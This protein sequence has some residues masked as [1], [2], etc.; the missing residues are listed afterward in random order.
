LCAAAAVVSAATLLATAGTA[1]T[2][3][4]G[5]TVFGPTSL[6]TGGQ[7]FVGAR[8]TPDS[9]SG[10]ATH[11][12]VT[13]TL[14]VAAVPTAPAADPGSS[15]DCGTATSDGTT[16][17]VQCT[18][19][20][21]NPGQTVKRFITFTGGSTI[22]ATGIAASVGFDAGSGGKGKGGGQVN[23]PSM[24]AGISIV[25]GGSSAGACTNVQTTVQ[26]TPLNDTV[27]QQTALSFGGALA[28]LPCSWGAVAVIPGQRG[29]DG[30]PM[31]SSVGGPIYAGTANLTL[32]F[33]SLPVPL[34]KYTLE[35]NES[36]DPAHPAQG[37]QP[38]PPCDSGPTLPS[39]ADACLIGYDKGKPIVAHLLY[40]GTNA[41]PWFN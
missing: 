14:P 22:G 24:P 17:T 10:A 40:A 31:I 36:F 6:T 15:P 9:S 12:V 32:T 38:V 3:A 4:F 27:A 5:F 34:N 16:W 33:A 30:A 20:T 39:G 28:Q 11:T 41:D 1:G 35:E 2:S 26:T 13:F 7:G 23:S 25:D 18:I 21:V 37:W 29:K 8:F 19:G